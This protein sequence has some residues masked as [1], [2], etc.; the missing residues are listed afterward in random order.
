VDDEKKGVK[1]LGIPRFCEASE[2]AANKEN[3]MGPG[4][5]VFL[6]RRWKGG[7]LMVLH[8]FA[9]REGGNK[10]TQFIIHFP[11]SWITLLR[12]FV[13]RWRLLCLYKILR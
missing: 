7:A 4:I 11:V 8:Y 6:V 2:E 3:R 10:V 1:Q 5:F 12:K 9:R 13:A